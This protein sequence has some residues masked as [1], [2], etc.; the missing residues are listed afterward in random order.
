MQGFRFPQ[1]TLLRT[2]CEALLILQ[3]F[4]SQCDTILYCLRQVHSRLNE[5]IKQGLFFPRLPISWRLTWIFKQCSLSFCFVFIVCGAVISR[6]GSWTSKKGLF[7]FMM[8]WSEQAREKRETER[9]ETVTQS[10]PTS[11]CAL[12]NRCAINQWNTIQSEQW[13]FF[14]HLPDSKHLSRQSLKVTPVPMV[15]RRTPQSSSGGCH[16]SN[17]RSCIAL[18]C[19][20]AHKAME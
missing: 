5:T 4:L 8:K 3:N 15:R 13:D 14:S 19:C 7:Q 20:E 2:V 18:V 12:I 6:L 9:A 16:G 1:K 11:K 17:C 10:G